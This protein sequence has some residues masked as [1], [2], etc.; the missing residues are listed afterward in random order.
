MQREKIP[1]FFKTFKFIFY[2][3]VLSSLWI[4]LSDWLIYSIVKDAKLLT[5]LQDYKGWLFVAVTTVL[6]YLL[7]KYYDKE[8]KYAQDNLA[9]SQEIYWRLTE[10]LDD[11]IYRAHPETL[12]PTYVNSA[13]QKI[14]GYS[15]KEWLSTSNLWFS[16]IHPEDQERVRNII[17]RYKDEKKDGL[18]SYRVIKK[19]GTIAWV[20]NRFNWEEDDQGRIVALNGIIH[21]ITERKQAEEELRRLNR[22]LEERVE[23]RTKYLELKSTELQKANLRLQELDRLKSMFIASMSHE[24]RTPLNSIIGFTSIL[25]D[26]WLGPLNEEQKENL[27]IVLRSGKHLLSL[28]NDVIDVSKI[29]AGIIEPEVSEFDLR[30]VLNEAVNSVAKAAEEKKLAI[31]SLPIQQEMQTDR[32]RLLQCILNLLSNAVKFTEK[33]YIRVKANVLSSTV[34][35]SVEDTG[36]GIKEEDLSH[37]FQPFARL[38]SPLKSKVLGTGLGLYLTKKIVQEILQGEIEVKSRY[39]EGSIFRIRVPIK[40][41]NKKA[42]EKGRSDEKSISD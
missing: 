14:Y 27:A 6:F 31:Q 22:E 42:E 11:L 8:I 32:R 1:T 2:Y 33:G 26:E 10:S 12:E 7:V 13:V 36:I 35:I 30:E 19:D 29:E 18:L 3:A 16:C 37:L 15:P 9:K 38:D 21:D 41:Q 28:I 5:T 17:M 40:I 23:E 20:E 24:L 25:L 39:G 4:Y 34:I